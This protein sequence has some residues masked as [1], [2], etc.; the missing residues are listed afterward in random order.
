MQENKL[1]SVDLIPSQS[2]HMGN[3]PGR[4]SRWRDGGLL[5]MIVLS[6][7][8]LLVRAITGAEL[9]SDDRLPVVP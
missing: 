3:L 8:Y 6:A 5:G 7:P 1:K 4:L 9:V 2:S